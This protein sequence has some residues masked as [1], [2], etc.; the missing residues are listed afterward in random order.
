MD[1]P[2]SLSDIDISA[3][4]CPTC[5][6]DLPVPS[7]NSQISEI[8]DFISRAQKQSFPPLEDLLFS[9]DQ[10]YM[11]FVTIYTPTCFIY[12]TADAHRFPFPFSAELVFSLV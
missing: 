10:G 11:S 4:I 9:L 5:Y 8:L 7:F 12:T 1:S 6:Q 2:I 3:T